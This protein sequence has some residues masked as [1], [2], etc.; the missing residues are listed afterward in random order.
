MQTHRLLPPSGT[1]ENRATFPSFL[2]LGM[3]GVRNVN[4]PA[5]GSGGAVPQA[6]EVLTVVAVLS[7]GHKCGLPSLLRLP[8]SETDVSKLE[9]SL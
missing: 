4:S 6:P 3:F 2:N 1:P 9:Q 5:S 7:R 8:V